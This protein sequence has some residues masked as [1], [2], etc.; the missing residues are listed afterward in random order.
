MPG[1][2]FLFVIAILFAVVMGSI[3]PAISSADVLTLA[4]AQA[5]LLPDDGSGKARVA[6]LFDLSVMRQ[7][8]W[9]RIESALLDWRIEGVP[10]D[11]RSSYTACRA[12]S[13][14]T[15]ADVVSGGPVAASVEEAATWSIEPL[16]YQRNQGGVVRLDLRDLVRAWSSG[17]QNNGILISTADVPAA[18]LSEQITGMRLVV[19]YGFLPWDD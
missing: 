6:V 13:A 2:G 15:P 4:P 18:T 19:R 3:L 1:R 5:A 9:R 14:W 17:A 11:R 10:S 8:P 7:G 12:L 16:D